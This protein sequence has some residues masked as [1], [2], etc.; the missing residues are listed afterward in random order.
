MHELLRHRDFRLLLAAQTLSMFGSWTLLLVFGIWAKTLTGS[1]AIAGLTV[2]A[3]AAPGL[4]GPFAGVLVDR[5]PRRV[6]MI[7]LNLASAGVV[8]TLW[9]VQDRRQLWLLFAV[10]AWYGISTI[11]FNAAL[12]GLV[13]AMLSIEQIGPANGLLATVKQALRL[14]GPIIGAGVFTTAGGHWVATLNA[15]TFLLSTVGLLLLGHRETTMQRTVVPF[16]TELN[17]G[18]QHLWASPHLRA[19]A[20]TTVIFSLAI[21]VFEPTVYALAD[22]LDRPP[23]FIGVL[24]AVQ[25]GGAILGGIGVSAAIRRVAELH[26][27]AVGLSLIAVGT[28]LC[29]NPWT[30]GSLT[31]FFLIGAGLPTLTVAG[32]T[33]LQRRTPNAMMGRVAASYDMIGTVPTTL[34]IAAGALLVAIWPYQ[35][36]LATSAAGCALAALLL[37]VRRQASR[38]TA[39]T[40]R[41][42]HADD[43]ATTT[44]PVHG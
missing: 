19:L 37:I 7:G 12:S 42:I 27:V 26:L 23:G 2:L 22:G 13:Q 30:S 16:R 44:Q 5:R 41:T 14:I 1:N 39:Q 10:A 15:A 18:L 38:T 35:A 32:A 34:S 31:G 43:S 11:M 25:G 24:V 8:S 3:M 21:G 4:I 33:L 17:A 36:I 40:S 9:F 20:G 29:T 28:G 6:V